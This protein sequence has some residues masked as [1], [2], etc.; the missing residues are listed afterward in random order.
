MKP[1]QQA[2]VCSF[3]LPYV[4]EPAGTIIWHPPI[5]RVWFSLWCKNR[6]I[7]VEPSLKSGGRMEITQQLPLHSHYE[8]L[9]WPSQEFRH[10]LWLEPSPLLS[11]ALDYCLNSASGF[12]TS[13]SEMSFPSPKTKTLFAV[14]CSLPILC[15]WS[16]EPK[17]SSHLGLSCHFQLTVACSLEVPFES[18]K[19]ENIVIHAK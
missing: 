17:A 3:F 14:K 8:I 4:S 18:S 1:S 9:G 13:L 19:C 2:L 15:T 12:I 5:P 7:I 11:V 10:V 16:F 6:R